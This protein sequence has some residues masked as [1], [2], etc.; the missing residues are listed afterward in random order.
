VGASKCHTL[1]AFRACYRDSFALL[2]TNQDISERLQY[3]AN[4]RMDFKTA[5]EDRIVRVVRD[6]TPKERGPVR[7]K[8]GWSDS[9]SRNRL[10]A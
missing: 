9:F 8:K 4:R 1:W 5:T 7:L 10:S 3:P 2:F 6:N